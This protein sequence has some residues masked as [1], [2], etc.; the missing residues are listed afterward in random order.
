MI[1]RQEVTN[2]FGVSAEHLYILK[3]EGTL[4]AEK[5]GRE[6]YF[7]DEEISEI[8]KL[9]ETIRPAPQD[10]YYEMTEKVSALKLAKATQKAAGGTVHSWN[11]FWDAQLWKGQAQI[12]WRIKQ[13]R[14]WKV[15]EKLD[16]IK[17]LLE[18]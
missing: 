12:R 4:K 5:R 2:R 6:I 15:Y 13:E 14:L 10:F 17:K 9:N 8:L 16:E 11:N 3:S 1:S 18:G 7:D